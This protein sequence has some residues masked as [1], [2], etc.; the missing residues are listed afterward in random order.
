MFT[1]TFCLLVRKNS[2]YKFDG[3]IYEQMSEQITALFDTS[4]F[5]L[6]IGS[7][8]S[9]NGSLFVNVSDGVAMKSY[10]CRWDGEVWTKEE[11]LRAS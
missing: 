10:V 1:M 2:L 3:Q 7:V 8:F 4:H 6:Y 5:Y 11:T 9:Y